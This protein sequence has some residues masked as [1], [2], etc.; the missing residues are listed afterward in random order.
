MLQLIGP[1]AQSMRRDGMGPCITDIQA[2][3]W[4]TDTLTELRFPTGNDCADSLLME[5]VLT[6]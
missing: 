1:P 4:T 2:D 5:R 3:L 6:S